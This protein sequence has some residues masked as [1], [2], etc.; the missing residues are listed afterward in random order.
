MLIV[1]RGPFAVDRTLKPKNKLSSF[2]F[3]VLFLS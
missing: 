2:S 3:F 1:P